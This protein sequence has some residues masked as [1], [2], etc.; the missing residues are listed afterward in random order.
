MCG[1]CLDP[2]AQSCHRPCSR[3]IREFLAQTSKFNRAI[4]KARPLFFWNDRQISQVLIGRNGRSKLSPDL[5]CLLTLKSGL[6]LR[7]RPEYIQRP[8][9]RGNSRRDIVSNLNLINWNFTSIHNSPSSQGVEI[10]GP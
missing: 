9:F 3:V 10:S 8:V 6:K 4:R 5:R 7:I 1:R 2:S